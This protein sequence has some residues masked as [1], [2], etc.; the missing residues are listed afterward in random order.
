M[1]SLYSHPQQ[2]LICLMPRYLPLLPLSPFPSF[3]CDLMT[4]TRILDDHHGIGNFYWSLLGPLLGIQLETMAAP[5]PQTN[6]T[7]QSSREESG[8]TNLSYPRLTA[9][10]PSLAQAQCRL[11]KSCLQCPW[12]TLEIAFH[13]P[14]PHLA[15]LTFFQHALIQCSLNLIGWCKYPSQS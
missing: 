1:H 11:R 13:S 8:S 2:P 9:H 5:S 7:H 15:A 12:H 3:F 14:S 4:L 10:R 6:S